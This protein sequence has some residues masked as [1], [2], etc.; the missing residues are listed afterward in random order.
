MS[1]AQSIQESQ[2]LSMLLATQ[3]KIRD[4]LKESLQQIPGYED[5]LA[6]IVNLCVYMYENKTYV[7]PEEKHMMVKVFHKLQYLQ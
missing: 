3:N 5:L 1:E 2:S 7:L 6:E 4:N